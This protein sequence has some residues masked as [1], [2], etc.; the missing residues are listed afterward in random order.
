MPKGPQGQKCP[1]AVVG[2]AVRKS[3]RTA[4]TAL[5]AIALSGPAHAAVTI[6]SAATQNMNCAGG[7]CAPTAT[8][9][10]LNVVDL[11]NILTSGTVTVTTTGSGVQ[12]NDIDVVASFT[13]TKSRLTLDA[14]ESVSVSAPIVI[15]GKSGLSILTNDGGSGG[16]LVFSSKGRVTF[17]KLASTLSINGSTYVL[18]NSIA[19]LASDI[20]ANPSGNYALDTDYDASN[21][22]TYSSTPIATGLSGTFEGLGNSIMNLAIDVPLGSGGVGLFYSVNQTGQLRDLSVSKTKI[23][24]EKKDRGFLSEGTV[25]GTNVGT[26]FRVFATGSVIAPKT[27]EAGGLVGVNDGQIFRSSANVRVGTPAMTAGPIGVGGLVGNNAGQI[28]QSYAIGRVDS[29]GVPV[30]AWSGGLVGFNASS[31]VNCYATGPAKSKFDAGGL[32]GANQGEVSSSYS[33]GSV[34]G[35]YLTGGLLGVDT[36]SQGS[37]DNTYWDTDSSGI[38]DPSQGAG[39]IPN[40]PG[41]TGLTTQQ[42]QSGLPAGFDPKI[43]TQT[44]GINNGLPYLI[45]N[46]PPK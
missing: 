41:I 8:D 17:T 18:A 30:D 27:T 21:D 32:I 10:T 34:S 11:E 46:P 1:A 24:V 36:S 20:A 35:T 31:I 39:N 2:N 25:A 9:A 7:V 12:A 42:L 26:I 29:G 22:G 44:K 28:E 19:M 3:K 16:Q 37:L 40:D 15:K 13:W 33:T 38:T 4:F 5:A 23:T 43:W 14:Y 45:N 6:S